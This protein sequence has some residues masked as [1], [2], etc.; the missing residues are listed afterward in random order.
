MAIPVP[1]ANCGVVM[2]MQPSHIQLRGTRNYC[3]RA[4]F[5][6]FR[7]KQY[8]NSEYVKERLM[9]NIKVNEAT[10]CWEWQKGKG[11]WGYGSTYYKGR[12]MHTHRL[13]YIIF[14]GE[15]ED[16]LFVLHHCDNPPC[17]NP[18][19]LYTGT[20]KDNSRDMMDRGRHPRTGGKGDRHGRR[21]KPEAWKDFNL[22]SRNPKAKIREEQVKEI[23]LL[24]QS[25]MS[26]KDLSQMFDLDKSQINRICN[27]TNWGH[28]VL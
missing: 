1:C 5:K 12:G 21:T 15:I 22:G 10:G 3:S 6:E 18:D 2:M 11:H 24:K 27:R 28:V 4:C 14:K 13:S 7:A 9:S 19:H 25:G 16:D 17:V 8:D 23:I 26:T 20:P